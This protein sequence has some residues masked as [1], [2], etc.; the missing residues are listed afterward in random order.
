MYIWLP[1]TL[2]Q[3]LANLPKSVLPPAQECQMAHL[4]ALADTMADPVEPKFYHRPARTIPS[5]TAGNQRP[6][7]C[8][9]NSCQICHRANTKT[10]IQTSRHPCLGS[11]SL[12]AE[13]VASRFI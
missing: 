12:A 9:A 5:N 8:S 13:P 11:Q 7:N 10:S 3:S 6:P 2:A 1:D 4:G